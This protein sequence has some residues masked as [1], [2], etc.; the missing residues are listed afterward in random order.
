MLGVIDIGGN[1]S[2]GAAEN[3]H[4]RFSRQRNGGEGELRLMYFRLSAGRGGFFETSLS[5]RDGAV[6]RGILP[7]S[8]N[9][10]LTRQVLPQLP[11]DPATQ[12]RKSRRLPAGPRS[13]PSLRAPGGLTGP[14]TA[15]HQLRRAGHWRLRILVLMAFRSGSR[16]GPLVVRLR[17]ASV[18]H[19]WSLFG[20]RACSEFLFGENY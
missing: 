8:P 9:P 10:S 17:R 11:S 6:L 14:T 2:R 12:A 13:A 7:P 19:G 4:P 15:R 1:G 16:G 3:L 18:H 20:L 5:P